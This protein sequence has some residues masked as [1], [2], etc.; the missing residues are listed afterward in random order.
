M[1]QKHAFIG[2]FKQSDVSTCV[3]EL[4]R[5]HG[6]KRDFVFRATS[7]MMLASGALVLAAVDT[8]QVEN[9]VY[10]SYPDAEAAAERLRAMDGQHRTI[11]PLGKLGAMPI[12]DNAESQLCEKLEIPIKYIRSLRTRAGDK[13]PAAIQESNAALAA[14]NFNELLKNDKRRF[15]VRTLDGNVRA[16]LSDRYRCIDNYDLFFLAAEQFQAVGDEFWNARLHENGFHILGV[17]KGI[18]GAVRTDRP[19]DPGD[20]WKSR[21]YGGAEDVH[22]CAVS[23]TNSETGRGG[24]SVCPSVLRRVCENFCIWADTYGV[25]HIGRKQEEGLLRHLG[26]GDTVPDGAEELL[27]EETRRS[28]DRTIMLKIRD[29]IKGAFNVERFRAYIEKLNGA[30]QQEIKK[31]EKAVEN[32]AYEF[33]LTDERRESIL[34]G[35]LQSGDRSR[36]GLVQAVTYAAHEADANNQVE[37]AQGLEEIGAA[38]VDMDDKEFDVL[39]ERNPPKRRKALAAV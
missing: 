39:A 36:Y 12:S 31:P 27:T 18:S 29:I 7:L 4:K 37:A 2:V 26:L 28:E 30:T 8:F 17:A 35:L 5:Q 6:A 33:G 15:L 23:I 24:L 11:T 32:V 20:G 9:T 1:I 10:T 14:H 21:W 19:F 38:I 3:E 22:N 25:I 34:A 13:A 16:V